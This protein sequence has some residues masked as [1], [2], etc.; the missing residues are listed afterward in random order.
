MS[1]MNFKFNFKA[2]FLIVQFLAF[3]NAFEFDCKMKNFPYSNGS[4]CYIV[5]NNVNNSELLNYEN[6]D[7]TNVLFDSTSFNISHLNPSDF[8]MC[9]KFSNLL[10]FTLNDS[11]SKSIDE[12]LIYLCKNITRITLS[13]IEI[14]EI[15][16]NFFIENHKLYTIV[17]YKSSLKTLRE[18]LLINQKRLNTLKICN[19]QITFL[20]PNI[21]KSLADLKVLHLSN[22]LLKS[23]NQ[24]W[25]ESLKNLNDLDLSYNN[26]ENLP[27][28]VFKSLKNLQYLEFNENQLTVI[29]SDSFGIHPNLEFINLKSNKIYA[30]D[31]KLI[32]NLG[33]NHIGMTIGSCYYRTIDKREYIKPRLKK[34][35]SNYQHRQEERKLVQF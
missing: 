2:I 28:N 14:T 16:E 10:S 19:S 26:I 32:D 20:P 4:Y 27:K 35:F 5:Q 15:P 25:F 31:E 34:C 21:F 3:K 23:L 11:N 22:N 29:H 1:L 8:P 13:S 7:V 12:N 33:L 6:N 17:L 24:A 9:E 18:N 30:I